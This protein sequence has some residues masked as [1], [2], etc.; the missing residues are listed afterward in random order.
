MQQPT[1]EEL[2]QENERLVQQVRDLEARVTQLE[3][4]EQIADNVPGMVYRY[5]LTRRGYRPV[6]LCQSG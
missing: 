5:E 2:Q 1:Y 3:V 6:Y 4:L